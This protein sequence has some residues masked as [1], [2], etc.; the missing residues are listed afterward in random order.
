[1]EAM[2]FR[3]PIVT[4][5]WRGIPTMVTD[6][7]NGFLVA[8]ENPDETAEKLAV[9]CDDPALR[10]E[11]GSRGRTRYLTEFSWETFEKNMGKAF[12]LAASAL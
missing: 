2:M 5:R 12:K 7:E 6:R 11:F 8:T 3:L 1:M 10:T 4:T 9:L